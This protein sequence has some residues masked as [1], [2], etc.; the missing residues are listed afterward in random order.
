MLIL[1]YSLAL[2]CLAQQP[3]SPSPMQA[4]ALEIPATLPERKAWQDD[5]RCGANSLY[6]FLRLLGKDVDQDDVITRIPCPEGGASLEVLRQSS[7]MWG[8]KTE[9]VK[10][11]PSN[12]RRLPAPAILHL[13]NPGAPGGHFVTLAFTSGEEE[14]ATI[15]GTTGEYLVYQSGSLMRSFSGY[16]LVLTRS[17]WS[18][19]ILAALKWSTLALY[20][21]AAVFSLVALWRRLL[22]A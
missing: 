19:S 11:T 1:V 5:S 7:G 20:G 3:P 8:A 22:K 2:F 6:V 4:G 18:Q 16:A 13:E 12:L 21:V 15:D 9:V 14:F 17:W 10:T